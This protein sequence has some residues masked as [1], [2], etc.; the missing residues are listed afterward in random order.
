MRMPLRQLLLILY[1]AFGP[2][3]L[4][5]LF[6]FVRDHLGH[7]LSPNADVTVL[8]VLVASAAVC[9][10]LGFSETR[11]PWFRA[12]MILLSIFCSIGITVFVAFAYECSQGNCL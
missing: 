5:V 6:L 11:S 8:F 7:P 2:P 4:Y 1:A 3:I 9:T 10:Y 12:G